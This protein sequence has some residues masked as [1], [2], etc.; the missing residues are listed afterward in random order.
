MQTRKGLFK[1]PERN[2]LNIYDKHKIPKQDEVSPCCKFSDYRRSNNVPTLKKPEPVVK[3]AGFVKYVRYSCTQI[4]QMLSSASRVWN[5]E[6]SGH[7]ILELIKRSVKYFVKQNL[8]MLVRQISHGPSV[9]VMAY[10]MQ[11]LFMNMKCKNDWK[12]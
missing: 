12:F 1:M 6:T 3:L 9:F 8:Y 5:W 10:K 2:A 11:N 4:C 7:T